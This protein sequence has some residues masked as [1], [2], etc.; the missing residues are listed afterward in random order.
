MMSDHEFDRAARAAR[1]EESRLKC[2]YAEA[3]LAERRRE[4]LEF[5]RDEM[6]LRAKLSAARAEVDRYVKE[7]DYLLECAP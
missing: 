4:R 2:E 6:E 5:A 1:L 3:V 7:L